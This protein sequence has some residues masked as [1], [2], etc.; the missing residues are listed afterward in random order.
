M[1]R[2]TDL[3]AVRSLLATDRPWAAYAL[4]DLSPGFAER[5]EWFGAAAGAAALVMLYRGA[6]PPVIVTLGEPDSVARLLEDVAGEASLFLSV[7]PEHLGA[8][9]A[10]WRVPA[11][12]PMWRMI[13][14]PAR[15][16]DDAGS[17]AVRLG[18]GNEEEVARLFAD[19]EAAGEAPDFFQSAMVGQGVFFGVVEGGELLAA[20]GTHL[21]APEEGVAAVGNVYTRRDHRGRG[22]AGRT[23]G[24]VVAELVRRGFGTIVLNVGQENIPGLRLYERLGFRRY[25]PFYE[26]AAYQR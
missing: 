17:R 1:P 22:L 14:D 9:E 26:G 21:L 3:A 16:P 13:L 20:A 7:R 11:S 5:C 25:C 8:V 2:L 10:R 24:A 23:T 6:T 15:V 12:R 4:G 18:P 19:G